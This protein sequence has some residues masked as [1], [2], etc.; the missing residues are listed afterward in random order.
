LLSQGYSQT[1]AQILNERELW[2]Y[3]P[4]GSQALVRVSAMNTDNAL[5][6]ITKLSSKLVQFN[7]N[8]VSLLGPMPSPLAKRASRF[9]YQLLI[10]ASQR[11][12]LH[13]FLDSI[14]STI[15]T[16]RKTG[17]VRWVIDVDPVDF[18]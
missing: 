9:R 18:L 17:G 3:P 8:E 16:L 5:S 11:G 15:A 12:Q 7:N 2:N 14:L 10:S 1:A 4:V 13:N 6:F